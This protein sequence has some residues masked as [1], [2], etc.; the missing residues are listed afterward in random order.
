M[1]RSK[2]DLKFYLKCDEIANGYDKKKIKKYLFN[3]E[4][5]F[6]KVL[7][8]C[9]YYLN[10]RKDLIGK[11]L[12]FY[13]RYRQHNLGIKLGWLI[14][15]NTFGPGLCIVHTGPVIVNANVRAGSNCRIHACVNI[16]SSGGKKEAPQ[17]GDNV[18]IG[19][20]TQIF[21]NI[22]IGSNVAIGAGSVVNKSFDIDGI[23]IAGVPAKKISEIGSFGLVI[24]AV[25]LVKKNIINSSQVM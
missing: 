8:K 22:I 23:T 24:D 15:P 1:I 11:V 4:W 18:Y 9:E 2:K 7:R 13:Y 5:R 6:H 10:C 12:Y 25:N 3:H 20:G 14:P 17:L 16:G 21:G 19:P